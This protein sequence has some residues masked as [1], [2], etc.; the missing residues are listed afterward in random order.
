MSPNPSRS[1]SVAAATMTRSACPDGFRSN[2]FSSD[3]LTVT[4]SANAT[5]AATSSNAGAASTRNGG[6]AKGSA[7]ALLMAQI[8][9]PATT[10]APASTSTGTSRCEAETASISLTLR[11][12]RSNISARSNPVPRNRTSWNS[13]IWAATSG[14]VARRNP[15][16]IAAGVRT[17]PRAR[18]Y[19]A[20]PASTPAAAASMRSD[21]AMKLVTAPLPCR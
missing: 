15:P 14:P 11:P 4:A 9:P 3:A 8:T 18:K 20:M 10:L 13:M 6:A 17:R 12:V 21:S 19:I 16:A 1:T 7:G 5:H 2:P